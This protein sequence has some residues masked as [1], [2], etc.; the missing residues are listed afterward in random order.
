MEMGDG[1]QVAMATLGSMPSLLT[2]FL[3]L[4]S[5][6]LPVFKE[7]GRCYCLLFVLQ[8]TGFW[9]ILCLNTWLILTADWFYCVHNLSSGSLFVPPPWGIVADWLTTWWIDVDVA[10]QVGPWQLRQSVLLPPGT[11]ECL[12]AC[13]AHLHR[14]PIRF[15]VFSRKSQRSVLNCF[16]MFPEL[17]IF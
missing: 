12:Y 11:F 13:K 4:H 10:D 6:F 17:S 2:V 14:A 3:Y 9:V 16:S 7:E 15:A 5:P 1:F 8:H